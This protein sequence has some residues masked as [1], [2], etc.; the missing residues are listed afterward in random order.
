M[1]AMLKFFL[2]RVNRCHT[3]YIR[4]KTPSRRDGFF[5]LK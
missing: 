4:H 5:V 3:S 2:Q 1:P